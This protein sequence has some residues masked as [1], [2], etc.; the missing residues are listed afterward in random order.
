[1]ADYKMSG[2]ESD[3]GGYKMSAGGTIGTDGYDMVG[4]DPKM[5]DYSMNGKD[6][7]EGGG[8]GVK[9]AGEGVESSEGMKVKMVNTKEK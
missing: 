7:G 9:M 8:Q 1:M 5:E 4:S 6:G 3:K 2:G